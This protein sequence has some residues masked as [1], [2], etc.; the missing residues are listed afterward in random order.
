MKVRSVESSINV[1]SETLVEETEVAQVLRDFLALQARTATE[2]SRPL[3]RSVHLKGVCAKAVF[4]VLDVAKGVDQALGHRLARG[5]YALPGSYAATVRFS[6][7]ATSVNDDWRPDV[8][9]LAFC[10]ELDASRSASPHSRGA[11]QDYS[12]HSAPTLAFN[13]VHALMVLAKVLGAP[14]EAMALGSLPF[15]DQLNYAQTMMAVT[16]QAR[17]PVRPYQQIRYWSAAPFRHGLE[18]VV[19]YCAS[20]VAANAAHKLE[21]R[22][23]NAL[24]DELIRHL[25]E[26]ATMSS[27]DLGI[28][29]LDVNNMTYQGKHHDASFWIENASVEWPEAQ[30]PFHRVARVTLLPKS[31]L[32]EEPCEAVSID[33]AGNS[34]EEHAPIG[35]LSRAR[36]R[37]VRASQHARLGRVAAG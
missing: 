36:R 29:F 10:V 25:N 17:Q 33:V 13:D 15:R 35:R 21:K 18:D 31:Q 5:I 3:G 27:F 34:L 8:R 26:D 11:R 22:H 30:A 28:Q 12:L 19:K 6:N 16:Q 2:G 7:G 1:E 24:R 9:G 20:P 4:E 37:A 23:T 32:S 14:N